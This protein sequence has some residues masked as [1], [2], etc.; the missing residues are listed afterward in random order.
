MSDSP[1]QD[2]FYDQ[3]PSYDPQPEGLS[4]T[5]KILLVL[6]GVFG[7]CVLLCCGGIYYAF[8]RANMTESTDPVDVIAAQQAILPAQIPPRFEP[9]QTFSMNMVVAEIE[10]ASFRAKSPGQSQIAFMYMGFPMG[11]MDRGEMQAQL[12]QREMMQTE[13]DNATIEEKKY[14]V[15]GREITVVFSHGTMV[16]PPNAAVVSESGEVTEATNEGEETAA[17]EEPIDAEKPVETKK[18]TEE[19]EPAETP[20]DESSAPKWF[21]VQMTLVSEEGMLTFSM[22]GPEEEFDQAEIDAVINSF[23]FSEE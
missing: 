13:I 14:Q 6:T 17:P 9:E 8:N 5:A 7:V 2:S 1:D 3:D 23:Q 11:G 12:D 18:A 15:D 4:S 20:A 21:T 19:E 16:Q 10:M 22:N